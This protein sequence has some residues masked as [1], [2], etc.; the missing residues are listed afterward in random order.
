[1]YSASLGTATAFNNFPPI[2]PFHRT[3]TRFTYSLR[4][5]ERP[6]FCCIPRVFFRRASSDSSPSVKYES[7]KDDFV[8]RVLKENPSQIEPKYLIGDRLYTWKEKESLSKKGF[9]DRVVKILRSLNLKALVRQSEKETSSKGND[10]ANPEGEVY[11]KDLLREYKGKLYV[12]EQVFGTNLSEEEEFDKNVKELPEMSYEDFQKFSQNEKVKLVSYKEGHVS[13]G[14]DEYRDFVVD[15]EEIPGEKRLHRTK[16]VMRLGVDL[17][18]DLLETYKGP[19]NEIERQMMS[20]LGQLPEYP[21]PIASNIS[22]RLMVELG[23]LTA[24][25]AAAAVVVGGFLAS[26]VFAVTSFVFATAV[27]VIWPVIKPI[28]KLS[29]GLIFGILERVWEN[30]ADFFGDG[31]ITSK[32]YEVYTFGGVSASIE[33]LKPILLVF[34]TMVL[35]VRFTLSRRPKNFR[36]WDIWQG[37]E[38]SQSKPQARV[39]GSTGVLFSDVAG[40]EEAVEELQEVSYYIL[41]EVHHAISYP[42]KIN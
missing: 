11:L 21:H 40:I 7:E 28:I 38:F 34:L 20:F 39:D 33:M 5:R 37:I 32:L 36:K 26:A 16:W 17:V 30:L 35:L 4:R 13:Y 8:T 19:R 42:C 23:V 12:P 14:N 24:T 25:L 15:L 31:G 29:L 9:N 10:F 18:K 27:Y 1:M 3:Q 41:H 2:S 22:S 6:H